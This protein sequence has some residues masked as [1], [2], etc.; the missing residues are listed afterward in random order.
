MHPLIRTSFALSLVFFA[1]QAGFAGQSSVTPATSIS[2]ISA[3]I[4]KLDSILS[5]RV[6]V[7]EVKKEPEL[8]TEDGNSS[9]EMICSC[10]VLNLESS[11]YNHRFVVL[12]AEKKNDRTGTAFTKA[13]NRIQKEKKH[14]KQMFYDKIQVVSE[15]Q[16]TGS[17]KAMFY[18]LKTADMSLQL[19][20]ILNADI[21]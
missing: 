8:T 7:I 20:E 1:A 5:S 16:G 11:N 9:T 18:R 4:G 19:Y 17:C 14:L 3:H 21:N 15:M 2:L 6:S 13:K 12:L 10:Q